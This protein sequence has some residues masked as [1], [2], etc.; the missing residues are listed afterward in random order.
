MGT[1]IYIHR[2]AAIASYLPQRTDNDIK[3]YWNTHL[4]K[5]LQKMNNNNQ[6]HDDEDNQH[7]N[8]INQIGASEPPN[9]SSSASKGQWERKLQ[10]DIHMAKQ[11]LCEALSLN[12]NNQSPFLSNHNYNYNNILTPSSSSTTS[13]PTTATYASSADNIARLLQNWMHKSPK[14]SSDIT[15]TTAST[16]ASCSFDNMTSTKFTGIGATGYSTPSDEGR[17]PE[18]GGLIDPFFGFN[19]SSNNNYSSNSDVTMDDHKAVNVFNTSRYPSNNIYDQDDES[20]LFHE[21]IVDEQ[22]PN[23]SLLEKWLF[24]DAATAANTTA[25][26]GQP[27]YDDLLI[28]MSF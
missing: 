3:N 27:Q 19:H 23:L 2:W 17:T 12:N 6:G 16:R 11:A 5:K 9:S 26:V 22:K 18:G 21:D 20:V 1:D 7:D 13:K 10:T 8:K 14:S 15:T 25:A 4:K 28:N 24:D